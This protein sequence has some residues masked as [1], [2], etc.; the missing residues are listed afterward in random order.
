MTLPYER[1]T[2]YYFALGMPEEQVLR[3]LAID[4]MPLP[5][6]AELAEI[7]FTM[8]LPDTFRPYDRRHKPSVEWLELTK[9]TGLFSGYPAP[10]RAFELLRSPAREIIEILLLGGWSHSSVVKF[11]SVNDMG[12]AEDDDIAWFGHLFWSIG[13]V[14]LSTL[15]GSFLPRHHL[16]DLLFPILERGPEEA[17]KTAEIV[18]NRLRKEQVLL[19][20]QKRVMVD[21]G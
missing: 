2:Q 8:D 12:T 4:Q 5:S 13:E 16:G 14:R 15:I 6:E 3:L 1:L 18:L 20:R 21:G 19:L 17:R 10:L 9:L 7:R 11:L